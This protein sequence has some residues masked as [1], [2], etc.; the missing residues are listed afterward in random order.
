MLTP[1]LHF[2][3][4]DNKIFKKWISYVGSY[5][6]C[7]KS[8]VGCCISFKVYLSWWILDFFKWYSHN[9]WLK[10]HATVKNFKCKIFNY[11]WRPRTTNVENFPASTFSC[12]ERVGL[13]VGFH[14][15][16]V[17]SSKTETSTLWVSLQAIFSRLGHLNII[18]EVTA[19]TKCKIM[20]IPGF[21]RLSFKHFYFFQNWS[22]MEG[23]AFNFTLS[24]LMHSAIMMLTW[25]ALITGVQREL[26]HVRKVWFDVSV[27][28]W[29]LHLSNPLNEIDDAMQFQNLFTQ[30]HWVNNWK[31]MRNILTNND[32]YLQ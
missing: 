24:Q 10:E 27:L 7:G 22:G 19:I 14:Q 25:W 28:M 20:C 1:T 17:F 31:R 3:C 23:W 32:Q 4:T 16:K 5:I 30:G 9:C 2:T 26:T 21:M 18:Q 11:N 29:R 15:S 13:E 6:S 12:E 8:V